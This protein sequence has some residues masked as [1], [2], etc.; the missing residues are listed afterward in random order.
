[1]V[2]M[3]S[4]KSPCTKTAMDFFIMYDKIMF[5]TIH[6]LLKILVTLPITTS[7]AE[8]SFSILSRLKN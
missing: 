1:M 3:Y 6:L 4:K 2:Y 5:L 7:S 8:R